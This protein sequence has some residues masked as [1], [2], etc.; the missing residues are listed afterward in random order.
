MTATPMLIKEAPPAPERNAT[1]N[2]Q[3]GSLTAPRGTIAA[4]F[5]DTAFVSTCAYVEVQRSRKQYMRTSEIGA[6]PRSVE[7]K[8]WTA[9][10]Y[11]SQT[12]SIAA[13]GEPIQLK[14]DGEWWTARLSGTH[15]AFMEFLCD[16]AT[17]LYD[18][19]AWRS[20]RG[21]LYGPV[22]NPTSG[23]D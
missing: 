9:K 16:S 22:A 20:A 13:G 5:R 4:M 15:T 14:I 11:P 3:G 17:S 18:H 1:L 19:V 21:T 7:A 10:V 6:Q 2:F 23:E 8:E 12:K